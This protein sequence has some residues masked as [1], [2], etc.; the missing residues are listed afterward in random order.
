MSSEPMGSSPPEPL[1]PRE[2]RPKSQAWTVAMH[3]ARAQV[4]HQAEAMSADP[5]LGFVNPRIRPDLSPNSNVT[6]DPD[7]QAQGT[8]SLGGF[9][10]DQNTNQNAGRHLESQQQNNDIIDVRGQQD[11]SSDIHEG[12]NEEFPA[13]TNN[14][15]YTLANSSV[16]HPCMEYRTTGNSCYNPCTFPC[17]EDHSHLDLNPHYVCHD[18]RVK[19]DLY[20]VDE[21]EQMIAEHRLYFCADCTRDRATGPAEQLWEHPRR[22]AEFKTRKIDKC[23]CHDELQKGWIC[24]EHRILKATYIRKWGP[25]HVKSFRVFF[26]GDFCG[27]CRKNSPQTDGAQVM[28]LCAHCKDIVLKA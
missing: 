16:D 14:G 1:P 15:R 10:I 4:L 11:F 22:F 20:N 9:G 28:W 12:Y 13:F 27:A 18:C 8:S 3:F 26:G 7:L 25:E 23:S 5:T 17:E 19:P 21:E 2:P 6:I 24:E